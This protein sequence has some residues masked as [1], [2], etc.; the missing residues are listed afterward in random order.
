M[1]KTP[2]F[3]LLTIAISAT[4]FVQHNNTYN[5]GDKNSRTCNVSCSWQSSMFTF[6]YVSISDC[7]SDDN[8]TLIS[9]FTG[10]VD[11]SGGSIEISSQ[12][13]VPH[14]GIGLEIRRN[15]VLVHSHYIS[16][17][18][19]AVCSVFFNNIVCTDVFEVTQH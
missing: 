5:K 12:L 18:S 14:H 11:Y 13:A 6:G 19:P 10:T 3:L 15:G 1:K 9:S 16:P 2:L 7:C 4:S 17:N 8:A